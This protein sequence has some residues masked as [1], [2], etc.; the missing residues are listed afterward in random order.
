MDKKIVQKTVI[1]LMHLLWVG[2]IFIGVSILVGDL[3][4]VFAGESLVN[5][6]AKPFGSAVLS[7]IVY[8]LI[9]SIVILPYILMKLPRKSM[10]ERLGMTK[11]DPLPMFAWALFAW[12]L[13]MIATMVV[14]FVLTSLNVPGLQLDQKQEIGFEQL[15]SVG[16]YVA[17]FFVLVVLA[18][19]FEEIIF[20]GYLQKR[21]RE[22][23][24]VVFSVVFSSLV[25]ALL[26]AQLNVIIGVFILS[27][28]IGYL[29]EK[30]D[31]IWPGVMVH[32]LK[33]GLAYLLL[34]ILP[35]YGLSLV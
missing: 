21:L 9:A 12:G 20:R 28:F 22:T 7:L 26:H 30:F 15:S 18:P 3:I 13:S 31:S 10:F 2:L 27:I 14:V 23:R 11:F 19:L 5:W 33:N 24:G 17:A 16:E 34:F 29:R 32:A 6:L 4:R 8:A 1:P 35:L 25:F